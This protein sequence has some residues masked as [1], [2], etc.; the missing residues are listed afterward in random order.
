[1]IRFISKLIL[2]MVGLLVTSQGIAAGF[3]A[4]VAPPRFELSSQSGKVV[5]QTMEIYNVSAKNEQYSIK[6]NDWSLKGNDLKFY[7]ALQ[8]NSCRQWVKLERRKVTVRKNNKRAFRFEV[9][10]PNNAPQQECRFAIMVEGLSAA[11]TQI[12]DSLKMPVNGRLAVIVYLSVNGAEPKLSISSLRKHG[13]KL[14]ADVR[15]TGKAHGRLQGTLAAVDAKGQQLDLSIS[16][17]PIM[18]GESR[19]LPLAAHLNGKQHKGAIHAP[20]KVKGELYWLK[21][22]F[23]IDTQIAR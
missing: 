8:P 5:R 20:I 10:I 6:T 7:D 15:N 19:T 18:S 11:S 16:S 21:G 9:H 17:M 22:A 13:N 14:V 2:G 12:S 3:S 4:A 23:A 1:M